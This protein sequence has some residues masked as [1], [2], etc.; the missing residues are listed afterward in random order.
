MSHFPTQQHLAFKPRVEARAGLT[1]L[2][3]D[4]KREKDAVL[5]ASED[6]YSILRCKKQMS[7]VELAKEA[8]S[9][10]HQSRRVVSA[11]YQLESAGYLRFDAAASTIKLTRSK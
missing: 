7:F 2:K 6:I 1:S 5:A 4:A 10:G 11:I 3:R 8:M 9:R